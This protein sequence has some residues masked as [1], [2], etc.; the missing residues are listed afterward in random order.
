MTEG[1]GFDDPPTLNGTIHSEP[2]ITNALVLRDAVAWFA[3]DEFSGEQVF[4]EKTSRR[5][6][7][8]S[9]RHLRA[10]RNMSN[11][12]NDRRR[13]RNPPIVLAAISR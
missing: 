4:L 10:D 13:V 11:S 5:L 1:I 3:D 9:A 8:K 6:A 7:V 2:M 12:Q